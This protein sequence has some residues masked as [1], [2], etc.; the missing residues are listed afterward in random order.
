MSLGI[1][2]FNA[3]GQMFFNTDTQTWNYIGSF[4]APA[5]ASSSQVMPTLDLMTET[6][7]QRSGVDITPTNQEGLIHTVTQSGTTVSA[8]GGTVRTLITVLGR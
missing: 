5:N 7:F 1:Q 8:T 4:I 3:N 6:L 2:L